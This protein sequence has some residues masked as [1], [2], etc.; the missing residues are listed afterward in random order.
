MALF[1]GWTGANAGVGLMAR[2]SSYGMSALVEVVTQY[3]AYL[4]I[5]LCGRSSACLL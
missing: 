2:M 4:V 3:A 1:S 5:C